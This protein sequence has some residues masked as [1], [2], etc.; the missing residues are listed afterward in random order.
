MEVK[1]KELHRVAATAIV[2]RPD[3]TYLI[4]KRGDKKRVHPG[5][6]LVPGGG[7]STDDYLHTPA[8]V[9]QQWNGALETALR[10]E[11]HEEVG[12]EI[13]RPEY[14]CD[15][16]FIQPN[17]T[18]VLVLSFFAPYVGG[19]V[20]PDGLEVVDFAW[21]TLEEAARYDLVGETLEEIRAADTILKSRR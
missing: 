2:Y 11:I 9:D 3:H 8:G 16:T 13:G 20:V 19:E 12:L 1:D 17:G 5:R 15:I 7:L 18:P 10:R 6:W 21:V 14:I 4:I